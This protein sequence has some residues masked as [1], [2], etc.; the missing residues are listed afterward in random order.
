MGKANGSDV[1]FHLVAEN[2]R[3]QKDE[4]YTNR[5]YERE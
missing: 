1:I 2:W 5:D 4:L 3:V